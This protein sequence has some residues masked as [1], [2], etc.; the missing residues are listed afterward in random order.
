MAAPRQHQGSGSGGAEAIG[1]GGL[2]EAL[3]PAVK[4][5]EPI[6]PEL[7][8]GLVGANGACDAEELRGGEGRAVPGLLRRGRIGQD[9]G[10]TEVPVRILTDHLG[11]LASCTHGVS[12]GIERGA[13]P[14]P[15]G[16]TLKDPRSSS[17]TRVVDRL[18]GASKSAQ[19]ER[20]PEHH[21]GSVGGAPDRDLG[22]LVLRSAPHLT[23]GDWR[24]LPRVE[25]SEVRDVCDEL[26]DIRVVNLNVL[27]VLHD[28]GSLR[29][30]PV[31]GSF[32][33]ELSDPLDG[34]RGVPTKEEEHVVTGRGHFQVEL[35]VAEV[36]LE[37]LSHGGRPSKSIRRVSKRTA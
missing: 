36:G 33:A 6:H 12:L 3:K 30:P 21:V 25:G 31:D 7:P 18:D 22:R 2:S 35:R 19:F 13:K 28:L 8:E 14:A 10:D 32:A 29:D 27:V 20:S 9:E 11:P 24:R 1:N 23:D 34:G 37:G 16:T 15:S 26:D 17:E 4:H 5:P